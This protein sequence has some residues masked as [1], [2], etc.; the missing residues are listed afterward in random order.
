[1]SYLITRILLGFFALFPLSIVH[2]LGG[3]VGKVLFLLPNQTRRITQINIAQCY[4]QY[5]PSQ[6]A[7]LVRESLIETGKTVTET[8][9]LWLWPGTTCLKLIAATS[10]LEQ[11][12][13]ALKAGRGAIIAAPHL[14]AWELVGLYC[15]ALHPMTSLYRPPKIAKLDDLIRHSRERLGAK[16]VP[17][18]TKG[19]RALYDA[20]SSGELIGILPDQDPGFGQGQFAPFFGI[21]ANTMVLLSRL[22]MKTKAPVFFSYAERLP[23][24]QGYHLHFVQ[25]DIAQ[26]DLATSVRAVNQAVEACVRQTPAQYQWGY[27]RFKTRPEGERGFY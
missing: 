26:A 10:G 18:E 4:P 16:L 2:F 15:S 6:Q 20:L 9:P 19:I 7:S 8:G 21:P 24:G 13:S 22:A 25:Q 1:M 23:H 3:L 5:N 12:Q 14:G 17:T 11:L 27:K